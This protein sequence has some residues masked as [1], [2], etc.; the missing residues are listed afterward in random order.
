MKFIKVQLNRSYGYFNPNHIV[1][2]LVFNKDE[3]QTI[4][5]TSDGNRYISKEPKEEILKKLSQG[6]VF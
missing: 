5:V 1:A 6:E 4:I 2:L 3:G